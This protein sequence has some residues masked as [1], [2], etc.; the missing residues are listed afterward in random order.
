[1]K[2]YI[3]ANKDV[4][5]ADGIIAV[6]DTRKRAVRLV[7]ELEKEDK[8]LGLYEPNRYEILKG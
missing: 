4:R 7:A 1:M 5:S 2:Q 8:Y 3:V 6:T